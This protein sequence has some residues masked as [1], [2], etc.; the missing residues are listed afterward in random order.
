MIVSLMKA[1]FLCRQLYCLWFLFWQ[2]RTC[3]CIWISSCILKS[4]NIK[5]ILRFQQVNHFCF[6]RSP[7]KILNSLFFQWHYSLVLAL[8][9]PPQC[10]FLSFCKD[11]VCNSMFCTSFLFSF[12]VYQLLSNTISIVFHPQMT[13]LS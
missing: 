6:V 8:L 1:V 13:S 10:P 12:L 7:Y 5:T 4:Y 11:V 9:Q 2:N 3:I